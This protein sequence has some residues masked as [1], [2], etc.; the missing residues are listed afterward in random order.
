METAID[1]AGLRDDLIH[2]GLSAQLG[3]GSGL[4]S[5]SRRRIGLVRGMIK[6]PRL[7]VLDGIAGTD[8]AVDKALRKAV[9]EALPETTILYA[10][11]EDGAVE[12]ADMIAEI[13]DNGSVAYN[14]RESGA[15]VS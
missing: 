4:S 9:R 13:A 10:A 7:M 11:L 6:R 15:G 2:L 12:G 8:S 1:E 5:A 14:A 3:S